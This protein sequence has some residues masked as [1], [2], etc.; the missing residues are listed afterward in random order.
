MNT[1]IFVYAILSKII[2]KKIP[3]NLDSFSNRQPYGDNKPIVIGIVL[4]VVIV[5]I[6]NI[7]NFICWRRKTGASKKLNF[8][9]N[10]YCEAKSNWNIFSR[11]SKFLII[12]NKNPVAVLS[13]PTLFTQNC[14]VVAY[15]RA[16]QLTCCIV[17]TSYI[18]T[19]KQ[20]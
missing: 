3:Y 20:A 4:A 9:I 11:E 16:N 6:G 1:N 5:L 14:W 2:S 15:E 17:R 7:F 13:T 12:K 8:S 18:L 19:I 10:I